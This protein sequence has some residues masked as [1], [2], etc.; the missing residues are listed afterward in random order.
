MNE[1]KLELPQGKRMYAQVIAPNVAYTRPS[2]EWYHVVHDSQFDQLI[3]VLHQHPKTSDEWK[4]AM[5]QLL[6]ELQQSPEIIRSTHPD[7]LDAL[8]KTWE[9]LS[10]R[11]GEFKPRQ[12]STRTS[13]I[14]WVN[15]YLRFRIRDLYSPDPPSL[16]EPLGAYESGT[17][18]LDTVVDN[19]WKQ[20][21][22]NQ[23][24]NLIEEEQHRQT[25]CLGQELI[26]QIQQDPERQLRDCYPRQYPECH[27]HFLVQKRLLQ[28]PAVKF[29]ALAKI[30]NMDKVK[31]TNHWYGRCL[32]C[33]QR[34]ATQLGYA[35]G[36]QDD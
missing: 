30:L 16:D 11:I 29:V 3:S 36:G 1:Y 27:C 10:R 18:L 12:A 13:M 34:M 6:L 19:I 5:N 23:L 28:E 7:Y 22:L 4:Q 17:T 33:L 26:R 32:P 35:R 21:T 9:W 14:H 20:P 31:L 15:G 8:H 24:D 2:L 25:V